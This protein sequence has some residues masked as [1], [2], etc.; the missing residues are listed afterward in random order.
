MTSNPA[1]R[2]AYKPLQP[3]SDASNIACDLDY[4]KGFVVVM[5][6][7]KEFVNDSSSR[8]SSTTSS[9]RGKRVSLDTVFFLRNPSETIVACYALF[10]VHARPAVARSG[11]S[12]LPMSPGRVTRDL[13]IAPRS[14]KR[15]GWVSGSCACSGRAFS[16]LLEGIW[17]LPAPT[18]ASGEFFSCLSFYVNI[19]I[20]GRFGL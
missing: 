13:G 10:P 2:G 19:R 1:T 8:N 15:P 7:V 20:R 5:E 14:W 9:F 11:W 18:P 6:F 17:E 12:G 3:I 16:A 4:V